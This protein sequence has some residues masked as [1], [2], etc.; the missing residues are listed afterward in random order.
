MWGDFADSAV[1]T[2]R[3]AVHMA[4][5]PSQTE[6]L[7]LKCLMPSSIPR[8]SRPWRALAISG[9]NVK[10]LLVQLGRLRQYHGRHDLAT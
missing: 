9:R 3:N 1:S 4:I 10:A 5:A 7:T 6:Q 8:T 2:N